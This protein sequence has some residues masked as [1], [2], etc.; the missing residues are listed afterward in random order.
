MEDRLRVLAD[1]VRAAP[2]EWQLKGL[3]VGDL[4]ARF[5]EADLDIAEAR[6]DD[7]PVNLLG[8]AVDCRRRTCR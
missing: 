4:S 1:L 8:A 5:D 7:V 2:V 3:D 6:G